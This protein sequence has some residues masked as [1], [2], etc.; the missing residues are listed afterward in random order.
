MPL[1]QIPN[2]L[3]VLHKQYN[4]QLLKV[5]DYVMENCY[6]SSGKYYYRMN[7]AKRKLTDAE[8]KVI[9]DAYKIYIH[10]VIEIFTTSQN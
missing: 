5:R 2:P 1:L 9:A 6:W 10:P 4:K 8:I 7:K 3:H